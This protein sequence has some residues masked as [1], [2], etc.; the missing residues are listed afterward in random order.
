MQFSHINVCIEHVCVLYFLCIAHSLALSTGCGQI[1]HRISSL[2]FLM[3][4]RSQKC[5]CKWHEQMTAS[6]EANLRKGV[7]LKIWLFFSSS[8]QSVW[9]KI[10]P[11][12]MT[13]ALIYRYCNQQKIEHHLFWQ[14]CHQSRNISCPKIVCNAS[15]L[16]HVKRRKIGQQM[17]SFHQ[18]D[19]MLTHW[20]YCNH[21]F[22]RY[23]STLW[24]TRWI[25]KKT[26]YDLVSLMWWERKAFFLLYCSTVGQIV[27]VQQLAKRQER[28]SQVHL[29]HRI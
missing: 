13:L 16:N 11:L 29:L 5:Y 14:T 22:A 2:L 27:D 28:Y 3:I 10:L 7:Y 17:I 9:E 8:Y 21:R 6:E 24:V 12:L 4:A 20:Q 19:F 25:R 26:S 1:W 18:D 23:W 15:N